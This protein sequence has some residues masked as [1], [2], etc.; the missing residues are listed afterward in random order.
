MRAECLNNTNF[1][2]ALVI[3]NRLSNRPNGCINKVKSSLEKKKK[4]KD[5]NLYVTQDYCKNE[6]CITA[7]YPA[8]MLN[9]TGEHISI[10]AKPSRYIDAA[11]NTL[12]VYE[13]A[14]LNQEQR[15]WE[16]MQEQERRG[17]WKLLPA[18]VLL[19]PL[20]MLELFLTSVYTPLGDKL[21]KL[22]IEEK[23]YNFLTKKKG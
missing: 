13:K 16:Q 23:V 10:N 6:I 1:E 4:K 18:A 2:G 9:G 19:M 15:K 8:S 21:A 22:N 7:K 5:Y 12:D 20:V 17:N 11:K 3:T 14:L